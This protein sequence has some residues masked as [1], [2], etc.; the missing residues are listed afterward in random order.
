MN[1][2]IGRFGVLR[3]IARQR[4]DE[5]DRVVETPDFHRAAHSGQ[6]G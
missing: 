5:I 1:G 6:P 3:E 2:L 4:P